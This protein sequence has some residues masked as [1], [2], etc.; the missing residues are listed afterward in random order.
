VGMFQDTTMD[1]WLD[2]PPELAAGAV[3]VSRR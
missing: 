3:S 2:A 1:P